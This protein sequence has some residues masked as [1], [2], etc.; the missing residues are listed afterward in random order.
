MAFWYQMKMVMK[1]RV[2][3]RPLFLSIAQKQGISWTTYVFHGIVRQNCS[4]M[5]CSR[6]CMIYW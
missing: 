6:N 4:L 5:L 3:T 1:N 2:M